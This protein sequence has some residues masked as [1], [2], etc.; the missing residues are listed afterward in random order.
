MTMTEPKTDHEELRRPADP[1]A[2]DQPAEGGRE[3]IDA[4]LRRLDERDETRETL[5]KGEAPKRT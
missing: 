2:K 3:Q 4:D 1:A 5:E